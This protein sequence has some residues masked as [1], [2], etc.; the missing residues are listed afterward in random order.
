MLYQ[1]NN[2]YYVPRYMANNFSLPPHKFLDRIRST[3]GLT[4]RIGR[5]LTTSVHA[6]KRSLRRERCPCR[7]C[8]H[9]PSQKFEGLRSLLATKC[10]TN[11]Q[12]CW[13]APLAALVEQA[14]PSRPVKQSL[15]P[16]HHFGPTG[17]STQNDNDCSGVE[18]HDDDGLN[19]SDESDKS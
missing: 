14:V 7:N 9:H 4:R 13:I 2:P 3:K 15:S 8:T 17:A 12:L 6:L 1:P 11:R 10:R 5:K 18:S 16:T 19:T